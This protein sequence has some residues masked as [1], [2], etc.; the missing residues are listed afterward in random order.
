M[1]KTIKTLHFTPKLKK[2]EMDDVFTEFY[3]LDQIQ[4]NED[5]DM[6]NYIGN[7]S[8][9]QLPIQGSLEVILWSNNIS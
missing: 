3:R 4:K 5:Q 9:E 7:C 2:Q 1:A 6:Q 8:R